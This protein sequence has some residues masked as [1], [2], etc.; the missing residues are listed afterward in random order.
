MGTLILF[1]CSEK[2]DELFKLGLSFFIQ[3][4]F[5]PLPK[6][7]LQILFI[8]SEI[9]RSRVLKFKTISVTEKRGSAVNVD[10]YLNTREWRPS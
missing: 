9:Y 1:Y 5:D 2:V 10:S 6:H 8:P 4:N 3:S 7:F